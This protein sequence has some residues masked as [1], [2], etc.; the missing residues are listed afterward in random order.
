MA[1]APRRH[2]P[3]V[4]ILSAVLA[5]MAVAGCA[6]P[7]DTAALHP[8]SNQKVLDSVRTDPRLRAALPA[9][10]RGSG[11]LVLG[12]N[13]I[14]APMEFKPPG[15]QEMHG[16]DLDFARALAKKLGVRLQVKVSPFD[17]LINS[18]NTGRVDVVIS[19]M[20]DSAIRERTLNMIDYFRSGAQVFTT[21]RDAG[22]R[23]DDLRQLCGKSIA[24]SKSTDNYGTIQKFSAEKCVAAGKSPIRIV[25]VDSS[26]S[27]RLQLQ[28]GRVQASVQEPETL[29]YVMKQ[30]PGTFVLLG[31]PLNPAP[32]AIAISK[33]K[34]RLTAAVLA[35]AR[36]LFAD[37]VYAELLKTWNLRGSAL[38]EPGLNL[39]GRQ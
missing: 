16:F 19:G 35:A 25:G 27:A 39:K 24:L 26:A 8:P 30:A 28:Q 11:R 6:A 7:R 1:G 9:D 13:P 4:L 38:S 10:I 31:K 33:P 17:Q 2:R 32:Y 15:S 23:H 3:R 22:S 21:A 12:L 5:L 18:L 29:A 14:F 20:S 36:E 34:K 37:G